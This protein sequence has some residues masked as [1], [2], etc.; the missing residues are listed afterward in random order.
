M[1]SAALL[2][3][4]AP[5]P[6]FHELVGCWTG[7]SQVNGEARFEWRQ[8]SPAQWSGDLTTNDGV[9]HYAIRLRPNGAL[10]YN[11][12]HGPRAP[13]AWPIVEP[14]ELGAS[15]FS[16][17]SVIVSADRLRIV[18]DADWVIFS[19]VRAPCP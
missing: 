10:F 2:V 12:D 6:S 14:D 7:T 19:G 4:C 1:L 18:D 16:R 5:T 9:L 15:E 3:A 8:D 13:G 17:V 11:S